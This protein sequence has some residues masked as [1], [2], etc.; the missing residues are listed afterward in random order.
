MG[1]G[2]NV[3]WMATIIG[4][5]AAGLATSGT[6]HADDGP[7]L[8]IDLPVTVCG[9]QFSL[10]GSAVTSCP[11]AAGPSITID[12]VAVTSGDLVAPVT[13]VVDALAGGQIT[14]G[15]GP[16]SVTVDGT[17]AHVDAPVV[18]G[19]IDVQA[20]VSVC[21]STTV[22]STVASSG[23]AIPGASAESTIDA[24]VD[25]PNQPSTSGIS[26]PVVQIP[27]VR[28]PAVASL[29][30]ASQPVVE[31]LTQTP[32]D[33]SATAMAG[34]ASLLSVVTTVLAAVGPIAQQAV[35]V[36]APIVQLVL[37]VV[38]V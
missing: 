26:A 37:T 38:G 16:S 35:Q 10:N 21:G 18:D 5:S 31:P 34:S 24:S 9:A 25:V 6:A 12:L 17:G 20:P 28:T 27:S 22:V 29:E 33:L 3:R 4:M 8:G 30:V 7:I 2:R 13:D 14:G 36:V 15:T 1:I 32:P 23:C 19:V 11:P